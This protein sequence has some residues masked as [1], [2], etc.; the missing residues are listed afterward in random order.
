MVSLIHKVRV[1]AGPPVEYEKHEASVPMV[2]RELKEL[3]LRVFLEFDDASR[4][5]RLSLSMGPLR[6]RE[7][8]GLDYCTDRDNCAALQAA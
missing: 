8:L 6:F 3:S 4:N 1:A 5:D 2:D 7:I